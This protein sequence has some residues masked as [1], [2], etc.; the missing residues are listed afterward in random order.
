MK[1]AAL[2][3]ASLALPASA[4]A[5]A[6][7]K[8]MPDSDITFSVS[9]SLPPGAEYHLVYEDPKTRAVQLLV[10]FPSGYELPAHAHSKDETLVVRKGKLVV[11]VDGK[12]A[13]LTA[14][15]YVVFPAGSMHSLRAKGKC[16]LLVALNGPFDVKG[17]SDPKQH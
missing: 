15:G 13:T 3:L 8:V 6:A 9:G 1:T 5:P 16:E 11:T 17:L 12:D 14:G 7:V 2:L 4:Q 10:R